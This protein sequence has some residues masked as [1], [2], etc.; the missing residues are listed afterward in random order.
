M[1]SDADVVEKLG[2]EPSS[3]HPLLVS[4]VFSFLF[5]LFSDLGLWSR[6]SLV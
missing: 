1:Q 6:P 2:P 5:V 4:N 3:G